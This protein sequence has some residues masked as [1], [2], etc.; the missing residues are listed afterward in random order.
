MTYQI[1]LRCDS[2]DWWRYHVYLTLVGYRADGR[3]EDY[4][5][6]VEGVSD[7][8]SS[9]KRSGPPPGWA[10]GCESSVSCRGERAA[11]WVYVIANTLPESKRVMENPDLEVTLIARRDGRELFRKNY[12][13]NPWGGLSVVNLAIG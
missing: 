8:W 6:L 10:P 1:V 9:E 4:A 11:V 3:Q 7:V 5:S 13:V 12:P 2:P